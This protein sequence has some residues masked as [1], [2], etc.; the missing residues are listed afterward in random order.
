[1]DVGSRLPT[2][3]STVASRG[4]F[5]AT[6]SPTIWQK[7]MPALYGVRGGSGM[8]TCSPLAPDVLGYDVTP[9]PSSSSRTHRDV[10][11]AREGGA[12]HGVEVDGGEV[13][14]GRR[15]HAREERVL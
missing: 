13:H 4:C 10:E 5:L 15:L 12:L 3:R 7:S 8:K 2:V 11:H 6:S 14:H 9:R 1:M